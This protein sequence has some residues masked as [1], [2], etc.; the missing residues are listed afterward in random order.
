MREQTCLEYVTDDGEILSVPI[1]Q[2]WKDLPK[3]VQDRYYWNLQGKKIEPRIIAKAALALSNQS[4]AYPYKFYFS[5]DQTE[6]FKN[7]FA[8]DLHRFMDWFSPYRYDFI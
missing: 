2:K 5:D 1:Y 3:D 6:P 7:Q 4:H 8:L